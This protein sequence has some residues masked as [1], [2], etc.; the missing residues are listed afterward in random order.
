ML[1]AVFFATRM[2]AE[3][4]LAEK[5][6]GYKQIC[7]EPFRVWRNRRNLIVITGIGLVNA[8]VAFAWAARKFRFGDVLNVGAAGATAFGGKPVEMG[9]FYKISKVVCLEPY[10]ETAFRLGRAGR[11]L[12]SSGSPVS[13]R[14]ERE[15]AGKFAPLVDM[16]GYALARAAEVFGKKI[17][18]VKMVTDFSHECDIS[19]NIK[20]MSEKFA[21]MEGVW[22]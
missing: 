5:K 21:Q 10:N 20:K 16:E 17:S 1:R 19:G 3:R 6:F 14:E 11:A 15:Y 2:E 8:S 18:M 4:V 22:I 13:T 7:A 9:K 12:V